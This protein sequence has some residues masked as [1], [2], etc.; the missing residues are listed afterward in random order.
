LCSGLAPTFQ[1]NQLLPSSVQKQKK[2]G[3]QFSVKRYNHT[4]STQR[5]KMLI[6]TAMKILQLIFTAVKILELVNFHYHEYLAAH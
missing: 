1:T 4:A 2:W 5:T 3:Q 6:F